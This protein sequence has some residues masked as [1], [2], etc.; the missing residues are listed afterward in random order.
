[1]ILEAKKNTALNATCSSVDADNA[2]V[3]A[4]ADTFDRTRPVNTAV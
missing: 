3:G 4:A 1:M 2:A